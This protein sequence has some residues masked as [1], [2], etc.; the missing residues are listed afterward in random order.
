MAYES[1]LSHRRQCNVIGWQT[2]LMAFKI[3]L[4]INKWQKA[5][6]QLAG[7][8]SSSSQPAIVALSNVSC[9]IGILA[10]RS[11]NGVY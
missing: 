7:G 1:R 3:Q 6:H 4:S 5:A 8:I 11:V 9:V 10:Q 2:A